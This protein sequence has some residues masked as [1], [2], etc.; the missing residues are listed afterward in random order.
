M[1]SLT[2]INLF[3]DAI[4]NKVL[5]LLAKKL[6][7]EWKT[8]GENLKIDKEELEEIEGYIGAKHEKSFKVLWSWKEANKSNPSI[9]EDLK[10]VL[11][12]MKHEA[13]LK[14]LP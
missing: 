5:L 2:S 6:S 10:N 8:L 7:D 1:L 12:K 4:D 14:E 11:K 13:L 9:V 3:T